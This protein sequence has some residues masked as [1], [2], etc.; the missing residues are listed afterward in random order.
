MVAFAVD[1]RPIV[2]VCFGEQQ[3]FD[4]ISG[5]GKQSEFLQTSDAGCQWA[6]SHK[7]SRSRFWR[8]LDLLLRPVLQGPVE[9]SCALVE[10]SVTSSAPLMP[11][12]AKWGKKSN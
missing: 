11:S 2:S 4:I 7:G 9:Y 1:L 8:S 10:I 5:S 12:Q 6:H 3:F